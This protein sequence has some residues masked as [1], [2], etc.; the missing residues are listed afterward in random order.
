MQRLEAVPPDVKE[1]E[2]AVVIGGATQ[3]FA[4]DLLRER[5]I[6]ELKMAAEKVCSR[7]PHGSSW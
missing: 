2:S 1:M 5:L 7:E 4:V 6:V 3:L